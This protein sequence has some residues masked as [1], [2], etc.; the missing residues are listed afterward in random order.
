MALCLPRS[1]S[2][3]CEAR[4][5]RTLSVPSTRYQSWTTSWPRAEKVF[6]AIR[7]VA[8]PGRESPCGRC[9][10]ALGC[11]RGKVLHYRA[12][13]AIRSTRDEA[14]L[15]VARG[16]GNGRRR[17]PVAGHALRRTLRGSKKKRGRR[18]RRE[19]SAIGGEWRNDRAEKE[20]LLAPTDG[21]DDG[22]ARRNMPIPL[23]YAP[24]LF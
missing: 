21:Y 20:R 18:P 17:R 14:R 7:S 15:G 22:I 16:R 9:A 23:S 24:Y 5:P 10:A 3:I 11:R 1:R 12:F 6:M 19:D 13:P 8:G 4:R 2:A